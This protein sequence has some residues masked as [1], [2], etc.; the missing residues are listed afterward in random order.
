[1][2]LGGIIG[3]RSRCDDIKKPA[4]KLQLKKPRLASLLILAS[5]TEAFNQS[6]LFTNRIF[7]SEPSHIL[8]P[9]TLDLLITKEYWLASL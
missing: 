4:Y 1:M 2:F 5:K 3:A 9:Q 6:I 8:L 7:Y